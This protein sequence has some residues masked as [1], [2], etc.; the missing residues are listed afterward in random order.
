MIRRLELIALRPDS[1]RAGIEQLCAAARQHGCMSVCVPGTR[2]ELA[3]TLLD[4]MP[5]KVAALIGFPFGTSDTDVK[6]LEIEA[7][8]D[9]GAQELDF[10]VNHGW[11]KDGNDRAVV[12]EM[13]DLREAAE[14]RP[15]KAV[16]ELALLNEDE[17][18]RATLLALEAELQFI[19]TATGCAA[20]P[21]SVEDVQALRAIAGPE[22]GIKAVG[23][24]DD[25]EQARALIRA[26]ANRLGVLSLDPF[27]GRDE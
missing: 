9:S 7:A 27:V 26:G 13:R 17:I 4:E 20:R 6:R 5:V 14:E 23:G 2:V 24:I 25:I 18:R 1:T 3:A 22:L 10:V 12:R 11:L 19:V 16:I 21:T 15:L 8:I